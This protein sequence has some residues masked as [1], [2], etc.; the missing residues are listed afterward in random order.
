M[1][2]NEIWSPDLARADELAKYN[3]DVKY[4]L[5]AVDYITISKRGTNENEKRNR[6]SPSIQKN[7]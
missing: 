5:V 7:D 2:I 1:D 3:R 4:L 6:G